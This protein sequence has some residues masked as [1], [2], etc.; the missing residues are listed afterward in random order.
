MASRAAVV[1][2]PRM[3]PFLLLALAM[4]AGCRWSLP[5]AS[6]AEDRDC[7]EGDVCWHD[8][9]C[10]PRDVAVGKGGEIGDCRA[11]DGGPLCEHC[12]RGWCVADGDAGGP[13]APDSG[14]GDGEALD[15]TPDGALDGTPDSGASGDG[16]APV[17]AIDPGPPAEGS[18]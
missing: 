2:P 6:C 1:I 15:G 4:T 13:D 3:A 17:G 7:A 18:A 5:R 16:A 14:G 12:L 10:L 11:V 8:G 9:F